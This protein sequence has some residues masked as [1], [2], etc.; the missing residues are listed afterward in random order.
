[1][2]ICKVIFGLK[3]LTHSHTISVQCSSYC[4]WL[5]Q[6]LPRPLNDLLLERLRAWKNLKQWKKRRKKK[7]TCWLCI[8][9]VLE[10]VLSFAPV[11][12]FFSQIRLSRVLW[13][14]RCEVVH[15]CLAELW[16]VHN[17]VVVKL[18]IKC[19][20]NNFIT[21]IL[22]TKTNYIFIHWFISVF[23]LYQWSAHSKTVH[24]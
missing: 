6:R 19:K 17:R 20:R 24:K 8:V 21:A 13:Q 16:C 10:M 7:W 2:V 23:T 3:S 18:L 5:I 9:V 4:S 15:L 11:Q 1:M 14:E 22:H 12:S